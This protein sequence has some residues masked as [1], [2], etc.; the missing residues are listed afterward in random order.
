MTIVVHR[1]EMAA[2]DG[3][4]KRALRQRAAAAQDITTTTLDI[5]RNYTEEIDNLLDWRSLARNR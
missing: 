1:S 5:W 4:L 2:I 3:L